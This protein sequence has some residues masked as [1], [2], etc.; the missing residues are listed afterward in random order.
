ILIYLFFDFRLTS[1]LPFPFLFFPS[2]LSPPSFPP[3]FFPLS[4]FFLL[5]P[6]PSLLSSPLSFLSFFFFFFFFSLFLPSPP[7]PS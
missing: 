1:S 2:L 6:F 4:P 5:S 3:F 7:P